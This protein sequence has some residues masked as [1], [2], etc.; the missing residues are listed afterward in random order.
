MTGPLT[1]PRDTHLGVHV[2][3]GN[4][5][6]GDVLSELLPQ[7]GLQFLEVKRLHVET[8]SGVNPRSVTDDLGPKRLGE[9]AWRLSQ[10]T[11]EEL[12]DRFGE[13]ELVS[14]FGH[15]FHSEL[16]T[17]H[18]LSQVTDDLGARSDLDDVS[19]E[20]VGESIVLLDLVPVGSQSKLSSLKEQV[21][22]L[23]SGHLVL[24]DTRV[25]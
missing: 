20:L 5:D 4:I 24:K 23:T 12:D 16:V 8:G 2:V 11:L 22:E 7:L 14:P 25:A 18:E 6:I 13:V 9:S 21:G 15:L 1:G 10:V 17:G 3:T 19:T